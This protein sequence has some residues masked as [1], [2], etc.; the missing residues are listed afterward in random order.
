MTGVKKVIL[1]SSRMVRER[2]QGTI[3]WSTSPQSPGR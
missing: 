3:G 2:N 1:L